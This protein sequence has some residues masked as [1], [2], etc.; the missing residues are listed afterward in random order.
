MKCSRCE[1]ESPADAD[2]C[3]ECGAKLAVV[4]A[5][6]G[7]ANAP[8]H[9]FC[10]KCGERLGAESG[11]SQSPGR[12]T[13]PHGRLESWTPKSGPPGVKSTPGGK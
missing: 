9:K 13:S 7:T 11:A 3:P 5:G 4:C 12:F 2:F 1:Q 10:K 8:S 6:C